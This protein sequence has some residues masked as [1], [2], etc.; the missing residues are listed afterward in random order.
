MKK[1]LALFVATL[2]LVSAMAL[3]ASANRGLSYVAPYGT[4]VV[5]GVAD[6]IWNGAVWTE[7]DLGYNDGERSVCS[8]R[9]KIL[10]DDKLIYVLAELTDA[11]VASDPDSNPDQDLLEFYIDEDYCLESGT[12]DN[13]SQL[14]LGLDGHTM[15]T[16]TNSVG[17]IED[18]VK[19]FK[20]TTSS[21]GYVMEF[22]VAP[23]NGMPADENTAFG[24]EFMYNDCDEDGTFLDA[25]RW[26]VDTAGGDAPPYANVDNFGKLTFAAY[27]EPVV[28]EAPAEEAPAAEAAAEA[29]A[30]AAP[31]A[32]PKTA[33]AG[34]VVAAVVAAAAAAVVLSKKH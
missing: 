4:P 21:N 33:D 14:R 22:S 18:M 5:D 20:V 9:A 27:V 3:T 31:A 2:M 29:P 13:F 30:A 26:N 1:L 16:G 23:M 17:Q 24:L 6:E 19:E 8:A 10:H 15:K 12:C 25:L 34:I 11:T 32:A 7:I 28:E